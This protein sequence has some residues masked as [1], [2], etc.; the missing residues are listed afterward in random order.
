M[1]YETY[2]KEFSPHRLLE[3][4][5]KVAKKLGG[6]M[7]YPFV[8]LYYLLKEGDIPFTDKVKIMGVLGYFILPAD[9]VPDFLVGVGYGDDLMGAML[10][11]KSLKDNIT[12]ELQAKA[13]ARLQEW[14]PE[15]E[16]KA[17]SLELDEEP[18]SSP[19]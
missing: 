16:I 3:K 19:S 4:I 6:K 9:V 12:P 8:L 11:L 10:L 15:E 7:I 14:L 1:N 13:K 5:A 17:V 2:G 18:L